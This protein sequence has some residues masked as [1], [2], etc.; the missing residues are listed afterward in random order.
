MEEEE[1]SSLV[2]PLAWKSYAH[3]DKYFSGRM[4]HRGLQQIQGAKVTKLAHVEENQV[5][6][7]SLGPMA[8]FCFV[9]ME[10]E[11]CSRVPG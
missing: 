9:Q 8:D 7:V 10:T 5:K 11:L 2:L 6:P 3:I 1:S 4:S